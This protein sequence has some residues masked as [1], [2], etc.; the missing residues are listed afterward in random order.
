MTTDNAT[1]RRSHS[2]RPQV[3]PGI[4]LGEAEKMKCKP[5]G[6]VLPSCPGCADASHVVIPD[7][8]AISRMDEEGKP[9]AAGVFD[10]YRR[11]RGSDGARG[12]AAVPP[13]AAPG[14]G[15]MRCLP[16]ADATGFLEPCPRRSPAANGTAR[17]PSAPGIGAVAL[18]N[19]DH[20][21]LGGKQSRGS[22][23]P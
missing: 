15:V 21:R 22:G 1:I 13:R 5:P 11:G 12:K 18:D 8:I 4:T 17:A 6:T 16:P 10:T 14:E 19:G 2:S 9:M 7:G 23:L 20:R 3:P